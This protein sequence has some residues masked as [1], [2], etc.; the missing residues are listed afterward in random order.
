[1]W[2]KAI[3]NFTVKFLKKKKVQKSFKF[4]KMIIV[5]TIVETKY[6]HEPNIMMLSG[7][8]RKYL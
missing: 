6:I 1:M 5:H 7:S 2:I 3:V 4:I 8:V